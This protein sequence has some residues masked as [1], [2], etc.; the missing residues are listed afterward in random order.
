M[1]ARKTI[2]AASAAALLALTQAARL[3]AQSAPTR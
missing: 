3:G 1:N 2:V